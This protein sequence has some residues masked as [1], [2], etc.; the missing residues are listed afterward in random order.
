MTPCPWW[1]QTV[2]SMLLHAFRWSTNPLPLCR[3][4]DYD[5]FL[6]L[7]PFLLGTLYRLLFSLLKFLAVHLHASHLPGICPS[8]NLLSECFVL[9][10]PPPKKNILC[11]H[12]QVRIVCSR[13]WCG[14][15]MMCSRHEQQSTRHSVPQEPWNAHALRR[16]VWNG[17]DHPCRL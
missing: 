8:I 11:R 14:W 2:P 12:R 17:D 7:S 16:A 3:R 4:T 13:S 10:S 9:T 15:A 5:C 1:G 6:S